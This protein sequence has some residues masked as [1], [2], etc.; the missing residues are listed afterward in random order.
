MGW[1]RTPHKSDDNRNQL[2]LV[3]QLTHPSRLR[4]LPLS[5]ASSS[6]NGNSTWSRDQTGTA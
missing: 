2:S 1:T 6:T 3:T 5:R 4:T